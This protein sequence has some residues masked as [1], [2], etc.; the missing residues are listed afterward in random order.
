[1]TEVK[2]K[3]KKSVIGSPYFI[4][5]TVKGLG[6]KKLNQVVNLKDTPSVR[7]M[8]KKVC[9]LVEVVE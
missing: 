5:K 2:V 6:L 4:K 3:L 7:G 8:I 1:M 9:H